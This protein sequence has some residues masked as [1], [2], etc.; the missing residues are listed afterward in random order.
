MRYAR[1]LSALEEPVSPDTPEGTTPQ[2]TTHA[3]NIETNSKA[4]SKS[5]PKAAPTTRHR[6][7]KKATKSVGGDSKAMKRVATSV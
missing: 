6:A 7:E 2:L 1:E 3:S 4:S 5:A